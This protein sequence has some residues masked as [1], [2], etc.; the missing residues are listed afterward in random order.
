[1]ACSRAGLS[2]PLAFRHFSHFLPSISALPCSGGPRGQE[3]PEKE[4]N[5]RGFRGFHCQ[6]SFWRPT[7]SPPP[8]FPASLG[9]EMAE[10]RYRV[11]ACIMRPELYPGSWS[12]APPAEE[13]FLRP[14]FVLVAHSGS[15]FWFIRFAK[16]S[17]FLWLL[18]HGIVGMFFL[19]LGFS[20]FV[21][22]WISRCGHS[23]RF[24]L[25]PSFILCS[26]WWHFAG[27]AFRSTNF[28]VA[29]SALAVLSFGLSRF[30][31][32]WGIPLLFGLGFLNFL[33][34]F[35]LAILLCPL[36]LVCRRVFFL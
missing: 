7:I 23:A 8:P 21:R 16:C 9:W 17:L 4:L 5:F 25:P 11:I 14:P 22:F 31:L 18:L 28:L 27:G 2:G 6:K 20:R 33:L 15:L 1:M 10:L 19:L 24:R 36:L 35:S 34:S 3:Q 30:V 13:D 26:L 12:S 32:L 29:G